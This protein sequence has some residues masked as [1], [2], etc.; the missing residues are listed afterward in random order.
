M[1]QVSPHPVVDGILV[2]PDE[3][4]AEELDRLQRLQEVHRSL[5]RSITCAS[6]VAQVRRSYLPGV[7]ALRAELEERLVV[8]LDIAAMRRRSL[9][10]VFRWTPERDATGEDLA[11]AVVA[12]L[13]RI[14][15]QHRLHPAYRWIAS[16][17]STCQV[18]S[19]LAWE[20][21][22]DHGFD[23]LVAACQVGLP[24]GPKVEL[25]G[26]YW[27]EMGNG[28]VS[29][30]HTVLYDVFV[31]ELGEV[32][33][34][35]PAPALLRRELLMSLLAARH[36][37]QPQMLGALG[38]VELQSGPRCELVLQGMQRSGFSEQAQQF[39]AVHA[40]VDPVH[41]RNWLDN[42]IAPM[43]RE[44]PWMARTV[45]QGAAWRC[46]TDL[47]CLDHLAVELQML[48]LSG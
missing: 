25:A 12:H 16:H 40:S 15:A 6:D 29:R 10:E 46:A 39:Y 17:A 42:A 32:P 14:A 23:D 7:A 2:L 9:A 30:S 48:Q 26:N 47:D 35:D 43:V 13:R 8:D 36:D 31:R 19:F 28:E 4:L 3:R 20:G 24:A 11:V 1:T 38:M 37:L 21:G 44:Q 5:T 27:D 22:P 45:I 41:G 18:R 33:A 34:P